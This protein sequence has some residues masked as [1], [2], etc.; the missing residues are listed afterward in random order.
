M[1]N[2]HEKTAIFYLTFA[3]AILFVALFVG[4]LIKFAEPMNLLKEAVDIKTTDQMNLPVPEAVYRIREKMNLD[5]DFSDTG[6]CEKS[7]DVNLGSRM[8]ETSVQ[9]KID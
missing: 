3:T 8:R 6:V 1:L 7:R 4:A 5:V 9:L 2:D